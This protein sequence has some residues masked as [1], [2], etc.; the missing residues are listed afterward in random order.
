MAKLIDSHILACIIQNSN[1]L[2]ENRL[3]ITFQ[4][5]KL[6]TKI[7]SISPLQEIQF[8][9]CF[10]FIKDTRYILLI[11]YHIYVYILLRYIFQYI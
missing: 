8:S 2:S 11:Y 9:C 3:K 6:N 7:G 1:I 5:S 4:K 10:N